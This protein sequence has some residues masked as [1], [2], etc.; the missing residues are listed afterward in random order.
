MLKWCVAET[1]VLN[2]DQLQAITHG[3][4]PLLIIAGA[5]TGKTT[6]IT[7]RIKHLVINQKISPSQILALTFT[8]KASREM[9]ERVDIALPYGYT[10]L[11]I[12][13]FHAFCEQILRDEAVHIGLNPSYRLISETEAIL[14]LRNHLFDFHLSY[15]RPLGNPTKFLNGMLQHFS[16]LKDED[17]QPEEYLQYAENLSKESTIEP[18]EIKKTIE[19]AFAY[20][21]YEELKATEG[22]MDFSDMIAHT[23]KLFRTRKNILKSYQDRFPYIL[24]DEFQDTNYAQNTLAI[25]LAGEKKNITVVGDDDQAIYRWRGAAVS[26]I[27]QFRK[28]YPLTR[29]IT[30]TK[31]YRST[32]EILNKSYTLIQYNNPDRLEVKEQI[33][34]K[35]TSMRQIKGHAV[36]FLFS[37]RVENEADLV[38]E[39]IQDLLN[40][41]NYTYKDIAILV[42]ANDYAQPFVRGLQRNNIPYQFLGPGQLFHQ[43][44]IKDLIAYLKVLSQFDDSASLYRVLTMPIFHLE[45]VTIAALLNLS[46]RKNYSLFET[47]AV[48][49]DSVQH[50]S[51]SFDIFLNTPNKEKIRSI[52]TMIKHHLD[53]VS[54]ESAGQILYYFLKDSGMLQQMSDETVGLDQK[55]YQNIAKFF[56]KLKTFESEHD[57]AR[58]FAIIEWIELSMQLGE[59]PMSSDTDW[60][61]NNAINILTIHSSKGLEFPIV[62]LVNLVNQRFP[63]RQRREQIP[64]PQDLIK[65]ILPEG[66]YHMQEER[67]LFYVGMTRARDYLFLTA[68]HFYG[69]GKRERKISPFVYETLGEEYTT[70]LLHRQKIQNH[71]IQPSLLDW[72][73]SINQ[74]NNIISQTPASSIPRITYISYSQLQ[75]YDIC[76]LHYKLKYVLKIPTPLSPSQSFGTSVHAALRSIYQSVIKQ[77]PLDFARFSLDSLL[78]K[79]WIRDGYSNKEHEKMAFLKAKDVIKRYIAAH[80]LNQSVP[81][82]PIAVEI[83]FQFSV[84]DPSKNT[85]IKIGG[86]IDRVDKI[87]ENNIEIIDYKTGNNMPTEKQL[88][89]DLQ[90]TV[91]A[92]AATQ[93]HDAMFNKQPEEVKLSLYYLEE[94]KKLTTTRTREQLEEGKQ[95]IFKRINDI[96][97]S[98]FLCSAS[99]FCANCEY[100]MLC[101]T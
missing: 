23:L 63:S 36:E 100:K 87:S 35:L 83:P 24:I 65:D 42:R 29:V 8:E 44:E 99:S 95:D 48:V 16:R 56:D 70:K 12:S 7:E 74:N 72:A 51:E 30:L 67:R 14:F 82:T 26:N 32:E 92:L 27:L 73:D 6:V 2:Q 53:L 66:D 62:F 97:T 55:K 19:L 52:Y 69:E 54:K 93:V 80:F 61:D 37:Q 50:E 96:A 4:G 20:K 81:T 68:A 90:L 15:F 22:I 1:P 47:L 98:Q 11:W 89:T 59:S 71:I 25:L 46:R 3:Q 77:E 31:N 21:K 45:S 43:E 60:T 34:K 84:K 94:D 79:V 75:T 18:D 39:K 49:T 9:E 64:I 88:A 17:I 28:S 33:N 101:A 41:K 86:R 57:D 91:Y 13:T 78:E 76:P 10:Q 38:V 40:K 85:F 5:G 58:V